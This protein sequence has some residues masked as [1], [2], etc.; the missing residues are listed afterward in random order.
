MATPSSRVLIA[1]RNL[2]KEYKIK[3]GGETVRALQDASLNIHEGEIVAIMG[4][5]GSGK[6]TLMHLIGGLDAPTSGEVDV[7]GQSVHAMNEKQRSLY[8]NKTIGFIFQF[9]YLQPYLTVQ[10]N[11][12]VPLMFAGVAQD[13]RE[14]A[15][16]QALQA[17]G[18]SDRAQH[19]PNQLSGGQMQRVAIAR[20]LVTQ[21]KILLADEP[22]GNLDQATG[23]EIIALLKKINTELG[24]TVVLVT[25]DPKVARAAHRIITV[26]DGKII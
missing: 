4:S 19:L 14:H 10:K 5:S 9:F 16:Q 7:D 6:S 13:V 22:T 12:E 24:T 1:V 3:K 26:S 15:A 25:H 20:A 11:I 21:P 2:R 23:A 8:R 17:V 18:L